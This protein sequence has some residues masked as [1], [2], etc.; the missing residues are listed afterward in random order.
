MLFSG[1]I[2]F[3][4]SAYFKINVFDEETTM[5]SIRNI[6]RVMQCQ[7]PAAFACIKGAPKYPE[8]KGY[9]HFYSVGNEVLVATSIEGIPDPVS[10]VPYHMYNM[11]N[12]GCMQSCP[13]SVHGFHIHEGDACSGTCEEPFAN[14]KG[15]YN[16]EHCEHPYHAGD[17]APLFSNDGMAFSAMITSRFKICDVVGKT[18]IL[19][20][21]PDDFTTQ[22]SGNSGAM[23]ACGVI[24]RM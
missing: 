2:K 13:G 12:T 23:I 6:G 1:C 7:R 10:A 20:Q 4:I 16:P 21:M 5:Y 15:H 17:L 24:K 22:P 8:I 14:A 18:I 11:K 3:F 9:V 19:H